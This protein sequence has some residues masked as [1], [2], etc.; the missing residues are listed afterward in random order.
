MLLRFENHI[1]VTQDSYQIFYVDWSTM[2]FLDYSS[3]SSSPA[4]QMID[5]LSRPVAS[6]PDAQGNLGRQAEIHKSVM[7]C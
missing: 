6:G 5:V 2:R 1:V 3:P 7:L 4:R